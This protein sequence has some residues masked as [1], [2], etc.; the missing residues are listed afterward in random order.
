MSREFE[1]TREIDLPARWGGEEF[2]IVLPGTDLEGATH[3]A[4][5]ARTALANRTILAPN[6]SRIY[7]TVSLGVTAFP[8][9]A[10]GDIP[11]VQR[12]LLGVAQPGVAADLRPTGQSGPHR[13][14]NHP[15]RPEPAQGRF[16]QRAR[17]DQRNVPCDD[18][19][20]LRQ[21]VQP[22]APDD[23]ADRGMPLRIGQKLAVGTP[24]LGH[25]AELGNKDCAPALPHARLAEHQRPAQMG[26]QQ[27]GRQQPE[28]QGQH[29]QRP[30][31]EQ[32]LP[33]RHCETPSSNSI[34]RIA[35]KPGIQL[36]I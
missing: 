33:S 31:H 20:Q 13:V 21:L 24:G 35:R 30:D 29:Q 17:P 1:I 23:A 22:Q 9:A 10:M 19:V 7:V 5:R 32:F 26:Q 6:G 3:L 11:Q 4:E 2:A 25:G 14:A 16:E 18:S 34:A 8:E 15:K 28:R 27:P 12:Q 36:R